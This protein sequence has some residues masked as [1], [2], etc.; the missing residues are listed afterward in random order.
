VK[1]GSFIQD[2]WE[3]KSLQILY[4]C[5]RRAYHALLAQLFIFLGEKDK[6]GVRITVTPGQ[7]MNYKKK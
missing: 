1:F 5:R 2:L 6:I 7:K 3:R 4:E